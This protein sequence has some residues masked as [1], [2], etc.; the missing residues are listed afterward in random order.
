[1]F[2]FKAYI[3]GSQVYIGDRAYKTN[4]I[5]TECLN[6]CESKDAMLSHLH[7][8][9][10]LLPKVQILDDAYDRETNYDSYVQRAQQVF[11][12]IGNILQHLPPYKDLPLRNKLD[13]PLLF[14]CLNANY[15]HWETGD[16]DDDADCSNAYGFVEKNDSGYYHMYV[17]SFHPDPLDIRNCAEDDS[18]FF[19][20]NREVE[21]LFH[22][23]TGILKDLIRAKTAYADF[24][25]NYIH[26]KGKFLRD[27]ETAACFAAYR[28]IQVLCVQGRIPGACRIGNMWAIPKDAEKPYDARIRSGKY[29]KI[30]KEDGRN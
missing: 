27:E 12:Y 6:A 7:D 28:R 24:L 11:F 20:L 26:S 23:F 30:Q 4:E 10:K 19:A 17:Q 29:C 2:E 22:Q 16:Y 8:L 21:K 25:D 5:L 9:E 18:I 15:C 1:M 13:H 3:W 14:D